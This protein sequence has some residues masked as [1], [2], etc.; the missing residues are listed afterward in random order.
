MPKSLDNRIR[1]LCAEAVATPESPEL[2]EILRQLQE[3]LH[4]H[5]NRL[6]KMVASYPVR[7]G[8]PPAKD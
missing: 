4:E 3:A 5:T 2:E 6:R 7:Q 1:E 8:P